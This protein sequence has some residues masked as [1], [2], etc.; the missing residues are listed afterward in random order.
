MR[1]NLLLLVKLKLSKMPSFHVF[2]LDT[3]RVFSRGIDGSKNGILGL[4]GDIF[5]ATTF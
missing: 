1:F 4:G 5:E 3:G 2:F